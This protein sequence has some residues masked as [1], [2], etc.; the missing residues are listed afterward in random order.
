MIYNVLVVDDEP[1]FIRSISRLVEGFSPQFKVADYAYNG[2]EA[3]EKLDA[4]PID[5]LIT[6]IKMPVMD[7]VELLIAL[8]ARHQNIPT[9]IVSGYQ[10]FEYAKAALKAGALDYLLKPIDKAQ[11]A[12]TFG[13][14]H[15]LLEQQ[16]S[17]ERS[18]LLH[19][20]IGNEPVEDDEIGRHFEGSCCRAV[21][22]LEGQYLSA[23]HR[24][25]FNGGNTLKKKLVAAIDEAGL[26]ADI[27]DLIPGKQYLILAYGDTDTFRL[28]DTLDKV[29]GLLNVAC[30]E[31]F[32]DMRLLPDVLEKLDRCLRYRVVIGQKG[33]FLLPDQGAVA[34]SAVLDSLTVSKLDTLLQSKSFELLADEI[35]RLY[36]SWESKGYSQRSI[37]K[38]TTQILHLIQRRF[39]EKFIA[40]FEYD[41]YYV[42]ASA[43]SLAVI[44]SALLCL[45][46]ELS[47]KTEKPCSLADDIMQKIDQYIQ[48]N[49][50]GSVS[51][52]MACESLC[53][54]QPY[55]SRIV[56]ANRSQSFNEY[57]TGIKIKKAREIMDDNPEMRIRDVATIVGYEDQ[58]Y[59]SKVFKLIVGQSPTEYRSKLTKN[60]N[61]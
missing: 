23:N 53:V 55:L 28:L 27:L 58:H 57:V 45:I 4:Q 42:I 43:E 8:Q 54:S 3:L 14:L 6:D 32:C 60:R 46:Y 44:S 16:R 17:T 21:N 31:P 15:K 29:D 22:V 52:Q 51:L 40:D 2:K 9:L 25:Y 12:E 19:K 50:D 37:E 39:H 38:M 18:A 7:G 41:L 10:D 36:R 33:R 56:R 59:F 61:I 30:S 26:A 24:M 5:V 35:G 11:F 49:L 47:G 13:A 34:E 1:P 20:L 48:M